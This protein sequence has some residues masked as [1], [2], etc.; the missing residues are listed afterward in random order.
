[1]SDRRLAIFVTT[2]GQTVAINPDL[3]QCLYGPPSVPVGQVQICF[4]DRRTETVDGE[5][6][7]VAKHLGFEIARMAKALRG[8]LGPLAGHTLPVD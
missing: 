4:G 3:V 1:M 2:A 8:Q 7:R 5:I 6:D